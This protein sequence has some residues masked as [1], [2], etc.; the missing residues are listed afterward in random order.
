M[1]NLRAIILTDGDPVA[2]PLAFP[3]D[4]LVIAAD[5]GLALASALHLTV[6]VV[7]GDM[8]SASAEDLERAAQSGARIERHPTDKDATDLELALDEAIAA[9]ATEITV[10]GG[11]G[12]R[13][14]HLLANAH[15]LS[16]HSYRHVAM[17][18]LTDT[19]T[20]LVCDPKRPITVRGALGARVSLIPVAGAAGGVVTTGLHWPLAGEALPAGSTRG[21]SNTMT[22]ETAS[23]SVTDGTLLVVHERTR[24]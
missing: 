8:D 2:R 1:E 19:D 15:L 10:V 18:W 5:G 13:L 24:S 17:R 6:D 7:V 12:G 21:M 22:A 4:A 23:V 9:G 16:G 14:D 3:D 11:S 20:V